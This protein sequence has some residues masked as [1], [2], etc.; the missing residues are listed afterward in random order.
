MGGRQERDGGGNRR[1]NKSSVGNLPPRL[2]VRLTGESLGKAQGQQKILWVAGDNSSCHLLS[3]S[4]DR[5]SLYQYCISSN[6][7]YFLG[8]EHVCSQRAAEV[9]R[10]KDF[11]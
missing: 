8:S 4:D 11:H 2:G 9:P 7:H 1:K 3:E 5:Q 10:P 6:A